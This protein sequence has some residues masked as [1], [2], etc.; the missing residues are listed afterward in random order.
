MHTGM[1]PVSLKLK[2]GF[3][4]AITLTVAVLLF[5]VLVVR[6]SR[7]E[8]LQEATGHVNQLSEVITRSTRFAMLQN[9]PAYVGQIIQDVG[10]QA[11]IEKVRILN[12]DGTIVHSTYRPE[13]GTMIHE[14]A[15]ECGQ[16]HETRPTL[17]KVTACK[18]PRIFPTSDGR[19]LL[20]SMGVIRNEPSCYTAACHVHDKSDKVLGYM[21]TSFDVTTITRA[22]QQM[23]GG[24]ITVNSEPGRGSCFRVTLP[25]P[26][27]A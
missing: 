5:T 21:Y 11:N 3:F 1:R 17:E 27:E 6:H 8:L 7:Q 12:K 2:I 24:A 13:I 26:R 20:G 14:K 10:D 15:D 4:L 25:T 9:Q 23:L 18:R 22:G 16:C 19:R